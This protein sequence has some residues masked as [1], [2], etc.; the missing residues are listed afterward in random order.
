MTAMQS[1]PFRQH[2]QSTPNDNAPHESV[3]LFN[4]AYILPKSTYQ[5]SSWESDAQIAA[6]R[7]MSKRSSR[8]Y[9]ARVSRT[10]SRKK[11]L[12]GRP[13]KPTLDT[14]F[15]KNRGKAPREVYSVG[16]EPRSGGSVKKSPWLG[17]SRS[18]A[19][20]QGLGITRGTPQPEQQTAEYAASANEELKTADSLTPGSKTWIEISPSDRPIPIGISIPS[21]S[22]SD[23]SPYQSTRQRSESDTTLV[24]PSI[25]ITP[26]AAMKSVWSPDTESEYTPSIYSRGTFLGEPTSSDVPPVPALPANVLKIS[27]G[28]AGLNLH[29]DGDRMAPSHTRNGT[30]DSAGTAFEEMDFE[31]PRKDRITS[32]GTVFEEDEVPLRD[33]NTELSNLSLDTAMVPTPRRS[34]GWWNFI[35]TPFEFSR[36][37]SV[38]TQGGR[39]VERTPDVPMVPQRFGQDT[40]SPATPSAYIWSATE[41]SPSVSGDA[42]K[43]FRPLSNVNV[44]NVLEDSEL[45][46]SGS[47]HMDGIQSHRKVDVSTSG[48]AIQPVHGGA[49]EEKKCANGG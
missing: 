38:W 3:I 12:F 35:T 36:A 15:T 47:L 23:F 16:V 20:G 27:E 25:I 31:M 33:R 48:E 11:E 30:L 24:T 45:S 40:D 49:T 5:N 34:R 14:S 43:V 7:A 22:I 28:S 13:S 1:D 18:G 9:A 4:S 10:R 44:S 21:D 41:K 32:T 6:R 26:A 29:H 19:K 37:N 42:R 2:I 39:N 46:G 17:L 8:S